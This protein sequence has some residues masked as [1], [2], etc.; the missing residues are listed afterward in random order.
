MWRVVRVIVLSDKRIRVRW[1]R[2]FG[3][4]WGALYL[5]FPLHFSFLVSSVP[6]FLVSSFYFPGYSSASI[7][8]K[9]LVFEIYL[10]VACRCRLLCI[11][12]NQ[13][14]GFR[15]LRSSPC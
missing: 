1:V 8:T 5:V 12:V 3:G 4:R 13:R 10:P 7:P 2:W 15:L 9:S 6:G 14:R 11:A